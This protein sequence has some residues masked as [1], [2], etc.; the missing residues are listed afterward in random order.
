MGNF[1]DEVQPFTNKG[2]DGQLLR[3]PSSD[4]ETSPDISTSHF[5]TRKVHALVYKQT[6]E[7]LYRRNFRIW[8]GQEADRE[9][10]RDSLQGKQGL[11]AATGEHPND[12]PYPKSGGMQER[13]CQTR[14]RL[15]A[16]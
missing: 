1:T 3:S 11:Q 4:S 8:W 13:S 2:S 12:P 16:R 15:A 10:G 6:T 7:E 14:T 9:R 5:H